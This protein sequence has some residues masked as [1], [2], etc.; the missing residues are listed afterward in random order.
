[1]ANKETVRK[2]PLKLI[3]EDYDKYSEVIDIDFVENGYTYRVKLTP[4]FEPTRVDTLIERFGKDLK[5]INE[6]EGLDFPDKLIPRFLLFHILE[7]F[8]DFPITQ[9]KDIT[10]RVAYFTQVINT[11]YYKETTDFLIQSEVDKVWDKVMELMK[12]NEKLMAMAKKVQND[13]LN[14]DLKSPELR[15]KIQGKRIPEA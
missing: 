7:E 5:N 10:K 13:L 6:T 15:E 3:K 1:M 11:K 4:L 9:T 8:S 2:L 14:L 12:A